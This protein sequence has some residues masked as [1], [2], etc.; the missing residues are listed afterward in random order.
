MRVFYDS[1][2]DVLGLRT[3][4]HEELCASPIDCYDFV[5]CLSEE[6]GNQTVGVDIVGALVYLPLGKRGCDS[7]T[8][9]LCLDCTPVEAFVTSKGDI[10][11]YWKVNEGGPEGFLD[12]VGLVIR[13]PLEHF[14]RLPW[15]R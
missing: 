12:P 4:E 10:T 5:V 15:E 9:S 2:T 14:G 11:G 13:I 1:K 8:D 6:F 7:A 3:G